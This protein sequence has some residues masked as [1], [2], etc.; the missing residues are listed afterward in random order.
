MRTLQIF[1]L[2]FFVLNGTSFGQSIKASSK[3][4]LNPTGT[5]AFDGKTKTKDRDIFG[6]FGEIKVK[7][8]D[9]N[10]IAMSFYICKGAPS[11]NS[12]SFVDTLLYRENIALYR[13]EDLQ[14]ACKVTFTFS[15]KNIKIQET[16]NYEYGTCW[17][18]GVIAFGS[19]KKTSY[20]IPI[21]K[22]PLTE[23]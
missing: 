21:I 20:K 23:E 8:I 2:L 19:F 16:A 11:Y 3:T 10:K 12:G 18:H 5:Y 6:Y 14:K 15:K 1:L 22:D 13:D 4:F 7:L 9:T 17:G